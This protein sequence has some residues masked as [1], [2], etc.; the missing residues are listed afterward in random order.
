MHTYDVFVN[1]VSC[2]LQ[3][4]GR[5]EKMKLVLIVLLCGSTLGCIPSDSK[6][7]RPSDGKLKCYGCNSREHPLCSLDNWK[8]ANQTV[9]RVLNKQCPGRL[10]SFC[11]LKLSQNSTK[12]TE[13]GCFRNKFL[14]NSD[15]TVGC[16]HEGSQ[17]RVCL[18]AEDLCNS[19]PPA[20]SSLLMALFTYITS[21][22]RSL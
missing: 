11:Y 2:C 22:V 12:Y 7:G 1:I 14:D 4:S 15:A 17:Y 10:S 16:I 18:C 20:G 6:G 21:T 5:L 9:R 19:A 3:T 8:Y 13:R